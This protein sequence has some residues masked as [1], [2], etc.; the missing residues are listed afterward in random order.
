ML[1]FCQ[2]HFRA[3][4]SHSVVRHS[5][6]TVGR[7]GLSTGEP[8][9]R[10]TARLMMKGLILRTYFDHTYNDYLCIVRWEMCLDA[11][12]DFQGWI[13]FTRQDCFMFLECI[14]SASYPTLLFSISITYIMNF[15][16]LVPY[17]THTLALSSISRHIHSFW[18]IEFVFLSPMIE[19]TILAWV[20]KSCANLCFIPLPCSAVG[21]TV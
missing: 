7:H 15:P 8:N 10:S 18:F 11:G 6:S 14:K 2:C 19:A 16:S 3:W 4:N 20:L 21:R 1:R 13:S 17:V 12:R 5:W 9:S